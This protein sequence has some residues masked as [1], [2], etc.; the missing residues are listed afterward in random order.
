MMRPSATADWIVDLGPGAGEQ[1]G[2][3]IAEGTPKTILANIHSL[4]GQ[5]LSGRKQVP[6]PKKRREG[7]GKLLKIVKA[8]ANNLKDLSVNIPLRQTRLHNGR[9]R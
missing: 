7:N 3:I 6:V 9:L 5:Y 1:G 8:S 4:T 2:R